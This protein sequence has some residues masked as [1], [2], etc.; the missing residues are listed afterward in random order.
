VCFGKSKEKNMSDD[1]RPFELIICILHWAC[2][3]IY[4]SSFC[5]TPF[6]Y[7]LFFRE[8]CKVFARNIVYDAPFM[9]S[10]LLW[11]AAF[12]VLYMTRRPHLI[13]FD[14]WAHSV[15]G[16]NSSSKLLTLLNEY[17]WHIHIHKDMH[18]YIYQCLCACIILRVYIQWLRPSAFVLLKG[19]GHL[20]T[21]VWKE[22]HLAFLSF[23]F[24]ICVKGANWYK[25]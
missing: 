17:S 14:S 22:S 8:D 13:D 11:E 21:S 5:F 18:T 23:N 4:I 16:Q 2:F 15:M 25:H 10:K 12:P 7:S 19:C 1:L 3:H 6:K 9:C 20:V 24:F